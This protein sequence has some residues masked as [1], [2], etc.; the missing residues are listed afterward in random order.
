MIKR[1][2]L[3]KIIISSAVLFTLLL[4]Y[5][6]PT[7]NELNM[8]DKTKQ[9]LEYKEQN[10]TM[11]EI[12]LL[13]KNNYVARTK[14]IVYENDTIS[15]VKE[16]LEI[17]KIDG[18]YTSRIPN[19]FKP[20]IPSDTTIINVEKDKNTLKLNFSKEILDIE[21]EY[22]EKL[23]ETLVYSLTSIDDINN[24]I[25]YIDGTIL[26][27]LPKTKTN[28]P[29]TL[30]KKIGINKEY[31][32]ES[33][34]NIQDVIIYYVNK[35]NDTTYYVPVTKYLNDDREKIKIII[36]ELSSSPISNTN[37]MSYLNSNTKLLETNQTVD[38]LDLNFNSYIFSNYDEQNILE[39]VIYT[40]GLSIRENYDVDEVNIYVDNKE[41]I[42]SV[43]HEIE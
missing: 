13:D 12:Y 7:S 21:K 26:N 42:K 1:M 14:V 35:Y 24:V 34:N 33:T 6:I 17:L 15:K 31:D 23:I 38:K 32:I 2:S 41:I 9:V 40:I 11:Q 22:E 27:K 39:E 5:I 25:I 18:K 43:L 8:V 10:T 20:I 30:N 36:E 37:L 3:K 29:S 19:G 16:I 4:L 28:L